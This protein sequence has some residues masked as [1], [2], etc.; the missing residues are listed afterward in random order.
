LLTTQEEVELANLALE[1]DKAARD[2]LVNSNIRLVISIAK[3]YANYGHNIDDLVQEGM[4]GLMKAIDKF[5]PS[6]GYR[7]ST[8]ATWW[9]KQ[10][11]SRYIY[12]KCKTI[13]LPVHIN[14]KISKI[15]SFVHNYKKDHSNSPTIQEIAKATKISK[16]Q[17]ENLIIL[18]KPTQS[19]EDSINQDSEDIVLLDILSKD[20]EG[21][22]SAV[23]NNLKDVADSAIRSLSNREEKIIRLKYLV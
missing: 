10:T 18:N 8:Y 12:D 15:K 5:D 4:M 13:R 11:I 23:I 19:I 3:K 21:D 20:S 6:M 22:S 2:R 16:E 1:G 7:L 9:I 14:E 17:I